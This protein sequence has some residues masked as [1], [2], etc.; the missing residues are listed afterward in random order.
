[1]ARQL[2]ESI[3]PPVAEP[4][5][6]ADDLGGPPARGAG[7]ESRPAAPETD[8]V[9]RWKAS[10]GGDTVELEITADSTFTWKASPQGGPAVELSGTVETA[11]DAIKLESDKAGTMVGTVASKGPAAFEF[12][13]PGAAADV[14]PLVFKRQP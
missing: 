8:L 3:R 11:A 1:V 5:L 2:L 4:P 9:G 14:P 10:S 13:L 12:S 7:A 6:P